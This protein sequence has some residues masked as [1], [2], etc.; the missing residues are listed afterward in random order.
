MVGQKAVSQEGF[1]VVFK[2][3]GGL[4]VVGAV[5]LDPSE[6]GCENWA[7]SQTLGALA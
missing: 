1:Q 2:V 7:K 3:Q 5:R 4:L 6:A